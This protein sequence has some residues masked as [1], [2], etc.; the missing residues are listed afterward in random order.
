MGTR[1]VMPG[2]FVSG[3]GLSVGRKCFINYGCFFDATAA[4]EI[5]DG[6]HIGMQTLICTSTHD[7]GE[8]AQRAGRLH[9][10]PVRVG[11]GAWLGARVTVLPGVT[12][13]DGCVVASGSVV[14]QDCEA[15]GLY[16][17]TPAR[18]VR[19]VASSTAS[20]G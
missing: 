14:T 1:N 20:G 5:G 16:A 19:D 11:R 13:G 9:G 17:G 6:C 18:R 3:P 10:E 2:C 8:A 15:D 4:I 7:L 12:I